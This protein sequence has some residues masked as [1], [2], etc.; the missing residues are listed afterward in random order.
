MHTD[1][2]ALTT[3]FNEK[4]YLLGIAVLDKARELELIDPIDIS[5]GEEQMTIVWCSYDGDELEVTI[6]FDGVIKW[7][8]PECA[9]LGI[10]LSDEFEA[11]LKQ[12]FPNPHL[13]D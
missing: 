4:Y 13:Y 7:A 5:V 11:L 6:S 12:L 3:N 9:E 2:K 10:D 8:L 1:M